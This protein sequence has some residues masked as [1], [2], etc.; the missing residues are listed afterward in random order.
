MQ[1]PSFEEFIRNQS[2]STV[3][4]R[5]DTFEHFTLE[6]CPTPGCDCGRVTPRWRNGKMM[7]FSCE[8]GCVFTAQRNAFTGEVM[9]FRLERFDVTRIPNA[10]DIKG[11]KFSPLGEVYTDWF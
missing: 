3:T 4:A 9:Y 5:G 7:G 1:P 8:F 11:M 6:K 2:E 10:S